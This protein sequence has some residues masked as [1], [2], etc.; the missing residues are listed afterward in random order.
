MHWLVSSV[1]EN[2]LDN[3]TWRLFRVCTVCYRVKPFSSIAKVCKFQ[4]PTPHN[5]KIDYSNDMIQSMYALYHVGI[6]LFLIMGF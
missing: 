4:P 6:V 5:I 1:H 2:K 3:K